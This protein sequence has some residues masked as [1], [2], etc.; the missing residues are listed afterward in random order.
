M[1]IRSSQKQIARAADGTALVEVREDGP[2]GGGAL[3]YRVQGKKPATWST[4]SCRRISARAMAAPRRPF[5]LRPAGS[6]S[7]RSAQSSRSARSRASRCTPKAARRRR[8]AGLV[9]G[10]VTKRAPS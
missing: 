10:E 6:A 8:R 4:S 1:N 3:T 5:R 9:G 7:L 2:E